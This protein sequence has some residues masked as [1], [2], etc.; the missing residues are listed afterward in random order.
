MVDTVYLTPSEW[1]TMTQ[2]VD[3]TV[4]TEAQMEALI[5]RASRLAES[6][7]GVPLGG[8]W[9]ATDYEN[10]QHSWRSTHRIYLYH[11]PVQTLSEVRIRVGAQTSAVIQATEIY[12]NNTAHYVEISSLALAFGVAPDIVSLGLAEPV[13]EVD[14]TAG[15]DVIPN[16]IKEAVAIIA[17]AQ[18]LNKKLFEEGSAGV[19]SFTIGSYQVS[20]GTKQ[21]GGVAGFGN[22]IPDAAKT[23][24]RGY[25]FA[26]YLR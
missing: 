7:A 9:L 24:L 12:M 21:L 2:G 14:Y 23:L 17:S 10:E 6:E 5:D 16:D 18:Y 11:W 1:Q 19:V 8:S 4:L 20:Y 22:Y 15:Y 3:F 25:R 26:P 13:V